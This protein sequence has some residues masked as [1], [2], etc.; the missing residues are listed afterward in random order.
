MIVRSQEPDLLLI[1]QPDHAAL[2]AQLMQRWVSDDFPSSIRRAVILH[3]VEQHD[4]GWLEPDRSPAVDPATGRLLDFVTAPAELRR[5][6]WPRGVERL[7]DTPYAAAL[8]AQHAIHVYSRYR[9]AA[10]WQ[11]FFDDLQTRRNRHLERS[12]ETETL[13]LADYFF[14]RIADL[15]SLVFCNAWTDE[16]RHGSHVIRLEGDRLR[17]QP[18]PFGGRTIPIEIAARRLPNR[19]FRSADDARR[20]F[21]DAPAVT[22]RGA[23]SA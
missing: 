23:A 3:A 22:V 18:D 21:E 13:L 17:V 8:V 19:P 11:P 2:A 14:L 12:G 1:T 4:N 10:E 7:A 20:A 9:Q 5:G 6:V 16:Q 15:M